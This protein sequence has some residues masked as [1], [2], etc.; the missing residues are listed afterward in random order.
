MSHIEQRERTLSDVDVVVDV[1]SHVSEKIE[2]ITPYID[3]D[4]SA[5]KRLVESARDPYREVYS[6]TRTSPAF[7]QIT[8]EDTKSGGDAGHQT[9]GS[10]VLHDQV[11]EPETKKRAMEELDIDY[12]IL[13]PGLNL[14]LPSVNHTQTAIALMRAYNE[15]LVDTF[16]DVDGLKLLIAVTNQRPSAAAD[17]IDRW[18]SEDDVVGVQL[19]ATG[20]V[21]PPG[22]ES[23]N[24]IFEAAERHGL[25]LAMHSG[26]SAS[27]YEF[28]T[29]RQWAETFAED[30][31]FTFFASHF[32]NLITMLL[33]GVPER[34][35]NLDVVIQEAGVSWVPYVKW[36]LDDHYLE[37]SEEMPVLSRLP[38]EY[39]HEQFYFS[40]QPLGH[41][42][43]MKHLAWS[44][45]MAGE[46]SILFASD[47]PH[48]D[49][50]P[51]EELAVPL[52]SHFDSET[53]DRI[54]GGTAAELFGLTSDD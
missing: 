44:I 40:S 49:F 26:N 19:P 46:E 48:P 42:D 6:K 7:S 10:G 2:D 36:R 51:P 11:R 39:I 35:P 1:D 21:P 32:W 41:T 34:Y 27:S 5:V 12:S 25:P 3:E 33:R 30:H 53:V 31:A 37:L 24:P 45:E 43:N 54:M 18:A 29:Q 52:Q 4:E 16:A 23:Y 13:T 28:P 15:W 20:L 38:S 9:Y 47:H 8:R 17:E 14:S 22:H 50:D